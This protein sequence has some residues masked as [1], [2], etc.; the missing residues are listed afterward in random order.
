MKLTPKG[1]QLNSTSKSKRHFRKRRPLN[2][3]FIN[4]GKPGIKTRPTAESESAGREI[5]SVTKRDSGLLFFGWQAGFQSQGSCL[6][7][8]GRGERRMRTPVYYFQAAS[9]A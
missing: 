3:I 2:D 8:L 7:R 1:G 6:L 9:R 5:T 4:C